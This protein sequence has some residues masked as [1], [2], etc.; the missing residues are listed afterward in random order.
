[1]GRP[2]QAGERSRRVVRLSELALDVA[3]YVDRFLR[4]V[5]RGP[6]EL[7]HPHSVGPALP[8]VRRG[9]RPELENFGKPLAGTP[10]LEKPDETVERLDVL[11]VGGD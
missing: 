5:E 7:G 11:F 6:E 3:P 1:M 10:L 2:Q 8:I 9:P 4:A